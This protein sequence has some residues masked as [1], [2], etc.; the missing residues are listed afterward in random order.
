MQMERRQAVGNGANPSGNPFGKVDGGLD[1][2]LVGSVVDHVPVDDI[3]DGKAKVF[4]K[5]KVYK[6]VAGITNIGRTYFTSMAEIQEK[7]KWA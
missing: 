3:E 5:A 2:V 1:E 4:E 6:K 7:D